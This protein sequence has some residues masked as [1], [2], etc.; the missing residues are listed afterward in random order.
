M[1][2][3]LASSSSRALASRPGPLL[4]LHDALPPAGPRIEVAAVWPL[5]AASVQD[6]AA[7]QVDEIEKNIATR[8]NKIF[9]LMEE[10]RAGRAGAVLLRR[11]NINVD[12][13]Q[14]PPTCQPARPRVPC[15]HINWP[16]PPCLPDTGW[17]RCDGCAS[18]CGSRAPRTPSWTKTCWRRRCGMPRC[19]ALCQVFLCCVS[20]NETCRSRR[21]AVRCTVAQY[22]VAR[23]LPAPAPHHT[24]WHVTHA[25]CFPPPASLASSA[26]VPLLHPLLPAHH[27]EDHQAVSAVPAAAAQINA[28]RGLSAVQHSKQAAP[29]ALCRVQ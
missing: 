7:L 26:G 12:V 6:F 27:R 20:W 9:L 4:P 28:W 21:Q 8:R 13:H 19:A 5:A 16:T 23:C 17:S 1:M 22:L 18:R 2:P 24:S 14:L 3:L 10:V 25:G 15:P 11:H 29:E